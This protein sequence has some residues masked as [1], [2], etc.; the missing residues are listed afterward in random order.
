MKKFVAVMLA[1]TLM[2]ALG[3]V[4]TQ[5]AGNYPSTDADFGVTVE[6]L[7]DGSVNIGADADK[8][9]SAVASVSPGFNAAWIY[10]TIY[11]SNPEFNADSNMTGAGQPYDEVL[12]GDTETGRVEGSTFKYNIKSGALDKDN[13]TYPFEEGKTY[14]VYICACNGSAWV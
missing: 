14:Y 6:I 4:T 5:A 1:L 7:E 3:A 8:I 10:I 12:A 11:D 2:L 13:P 9:N